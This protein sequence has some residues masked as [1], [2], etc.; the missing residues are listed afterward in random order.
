MM[1]P[2]QISCECGLL[3]QALLDW[4]WFLQSSFLLIIKLKTYNMLRKGQPAK[5][6]AFGGGSLCIMSLCTCVWVSN[7]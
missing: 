2:Y 4:S 7:V 5:G 6:K 3:I 1:T